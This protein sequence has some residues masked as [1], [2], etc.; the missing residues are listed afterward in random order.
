MKKN[1]YTNLS[2]LVF[3]GILISYIC[4]MSPAPFLPAIKAAYGV[5]GDALLNLSVSVIYPLLILTSLCG[6]SLLGRLGLSR[7]FAV[8]LLLL[9]AGILMNYA[10]S[11]YVLFLLGRMIFGAGFGLGIPFI[12]AYIMELYRGR[13]RETLNSLNALFPFFGTL[14]SFALMDTL[15]GSL[16]GGWK[17]A[18]GVWGFGTLAVLICWL[19]AVRNTPR[20]AAEALLARGGARQAPERHLYRNLLRR[21]EIALLCV[22]FMC[23]YFCYSYLVTIL[24]TLLMERCS[25]SAAAASLISALVF[26]GVGCVGCVLAGIVTARTGL[27]KPAL[28]AGTALELAGLLLSTLPG[29]DSNLH[30]YLGIAC[31]AFGNGYWL[32]VLYMIPMD[33]PDMNPQRAGASF[34]LTSTCAFLFG[35]ISPSIGGKL[36]DVIAAKSAAAGTAAHA[37][38]L[39]WSLC[40]FSAVMAVGFAAALR[41]RETSPAAGGPRKTPDTRPGA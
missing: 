11:S 33:L 40:C 16:R 32:P 15:A 8:I 13:Q 27:R 22:I 34:A 28:V 2:V 3:L 36:T 29:G 20:G 38:G 26:P 41:I 5:N 1:Y 31:F 17:G 23:D 35:F 25:L 6:S 24:P 21:R 9:S 37:A 12:G 14:I 18:L 30:V 7:S 10:A 39:R 4:Q 19:L